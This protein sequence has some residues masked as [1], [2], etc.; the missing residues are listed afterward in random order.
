LDS[1]RPVIL[2]CDSEEAGELQI[3]IQQALAW[4]EIAV[5]FGDSSVMDMAV[6]AD[7]FPVSIRDIAAANFFVMQVLGPNFDRF[8][9][10]DAR[11]RAALRKP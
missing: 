1:S 11:N 2:L 10:L 5:R 9:Q 6:N 4:S 8:I 7:H 3:R